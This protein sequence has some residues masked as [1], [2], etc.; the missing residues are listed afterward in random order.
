MNVAETPIL[1]ALIHTVER[2]RVPLHVPGHKQGRV[3]PSAFATWLGQAAK[4]DLTELPGLDNLH[5]PDGCILA[6]QQLTAA[7]YGSDQCLYSVNGSSA[8][9]MAAILACAEGRKVLFAG[10]FHQSAWRGLVLAD[11][12]PVFLPSRF[13]AEQCRHEPPSPEHLRQALAAH[14]DTAAVFVTSPTYHGVVADVATLAEICHSEGVPLIVDEAHGAHFGLI[15]A[16]PKHSVA[17]GADVVIQSVHKMLPGLT[18]TAWV[19]VT[20]DL[21]SAATLER[22]LLTLQTT[23]PSYLLLASLDV[24]QAWL[25]EEGPRVATETM[26]VLAEAGLLPSE[27]P[28]ADPL[29][30]WLPTGSLELSMTIRSALQESGIYVELADGLGVLSVFGF[31][32]TRAEV[33][34]YLSVVNRVLQQ[35]P[36]SRATGFVPYE[37][38]QMGTLAI[39]PR[40]AFGKPAE[41]VPV[42]KALGRVS[43]GMVTPYPPGVPVVVPG[44]RL[45]EPCVQM[46][47]ALSDMHSD[48]HGMRDGL[49]A[50][51]QDETT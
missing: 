13:H 46:L 26:N 34:R 10:P 50:V 31:G 32:I 18:Q 3:L 20:G 48:I 49:I 25:R 1:D 6:S 16:F 47:T 9:I 8:G 36:T 29:R 30:H 24:A 39:R 37:L 42:Q 15:E 33:S 38:E 27:M 19:H 51:L 23:S 5:Q 45:D 12:E 28:F 40:R 7:Y 4:L 43:A 41:W 44:Q 17:A 2:L 11:A 21:V 14:P 35:T 22:W